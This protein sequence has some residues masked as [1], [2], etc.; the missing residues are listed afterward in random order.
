MDK[1]AVAAVMVIEPDELPSAQQNC[2]EIGP[3][4]DFIQH[5]VL[6]EDNKLRKLAHQEDQYIIIDDVLYHELDHSK[7]RLEL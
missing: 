1:D 7:V 6:P 3:Y 5:G 2:P 4:Y